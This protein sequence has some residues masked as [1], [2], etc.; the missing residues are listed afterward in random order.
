[1]IVKP[2]PQR[3]T[4]IKPNVKV[5][6]EGCSIVIIISPLRLM[7]PR[8]LF[9]HKSFLF[10]GQQK[11]TRHKILCLVIHILG[12]QL[13]IAQAIPFSLANIDQLVR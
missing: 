8:K 3:K 7:F 13:K 10:P 9:Y 1:M 6:L 2:I 12:F 4:E 11:M 5:C